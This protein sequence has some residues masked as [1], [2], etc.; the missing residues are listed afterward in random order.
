MLGFSPISQPDDKYHPLKVKVKTGDHVQ[1]RPGYFSEKQ[2]VPIQLR[3]D[4][5]AASKDTMEEIPATIHISGAVQVEITVDA[6]FLKFTEQSGRRLQQ[7]TFVT[8]ILDP[9]GNIVEGKQAVVDLAVTPGKLSELESQG[10]EATTNFSLPPG[11][12]QLREIIREAQQN[13]FTARTLP[14]P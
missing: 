1:S 8:L 11:H 10:I 3:I 14:V 5:L 7:L 13:H 9:S 12:Y 4:R 2:P 6:R